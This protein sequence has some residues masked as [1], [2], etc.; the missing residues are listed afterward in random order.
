[1]NEPKGK[2]EKQYQLSKEQ[3]SEMSYVATQR[4]ASMEVAN[5]W[6]KRLDRFMAG[7]RSVLGIP[8]EYDVNWNDAFNKG[9]ITAIPKELPKKEE[10]HAS[11]NKKV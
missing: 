1:M 3:L 7:V 5:F 10:A 11:D 9:T 6:D 2:K 4:T 8:S